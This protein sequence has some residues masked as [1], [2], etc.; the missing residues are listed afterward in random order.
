MHPCQECGE[1]MTRFDG[2]FC[3][4]GECEGYCEY[5]YEC[6]VLGCPLEGEHQ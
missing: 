5:W 3:D 1:E 6:Q 4:D 2:C